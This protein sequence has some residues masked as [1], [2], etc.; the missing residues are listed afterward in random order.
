MASVEGAPA[1]YSPHT[2]LLLAVSLR[3]GTFCVSPPLPPVFFTSDPLQSLLQSIVVQVCRIVLLTSSPCSWSEKPISSL[4]QCCPSVFLSHSSVSL[5]LFLHNISWPALLQIRHVVFVLSCMIWASLS[6]CFN[7]SFCTFSK[8]NWSFL[9]TA[10]KK[11]THSMYCVT[12]NAAIT[13]IYSCLLKHL[14]I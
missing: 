14:K 1:P 5:I 8:F 7:I 9:I 4:C 3:G 11:Y 6:H 13:L 12:Y 2:A 10:D